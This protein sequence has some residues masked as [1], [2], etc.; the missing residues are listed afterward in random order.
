MHEMA[1]DRDFFFEPPEGW[2]DKTIVAFSA[3]EGETAMAANFVVTSE[4]L[5]DGEDLR[6]HVDR[7]LLLAARQL[8]EFE[9]IET[10]ETTLGGLEAVC[11]RFTW[12]APFGE[13]EQAITSVRRV[14]AGAACVTSVSTTAAAADVASSRASFANV[15]ASFRFADA[16]P[17]P[18]AC[19]QAAEAPLLPLVMPMPGERR[20]LRESRPR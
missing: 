3:P 8:R 17:P 5:R 18:P 11:A 10:R 20:A 2:V 16:P 4:P 19:I 14:V 12:L 9:L 13:V 6:T 1:Q 15:L 7:Y